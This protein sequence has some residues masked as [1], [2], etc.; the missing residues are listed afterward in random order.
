MNKEWCYNAI[1]CFVFSRNKAKSIPI[2]IIKYK[3]VVEFVFNLV[4]YFYRCIL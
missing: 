3:I 1:Y 4:R 2:S